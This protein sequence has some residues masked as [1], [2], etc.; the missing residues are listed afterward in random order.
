MA[1]A[2]T[3]ALTFRIEPGLK[4]SSRNVGRYLFS[5]KTDIDSIELLY[6]DRELTLGF[7]TTRHR[8]AS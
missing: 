3:T 4:E 5:T 8:A 1:T 2:K 6:R 7:M